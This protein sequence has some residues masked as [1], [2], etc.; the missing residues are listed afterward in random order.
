[1][2]CCMSYRPYPTK[3][4]H[5]LRYVLRNRSSSEVYLVILFTLYLKEDIN[6]DGSLKPAAVE[7]TKLAS[8]RVLRS[9][10]PA[11]HDCPPINE[12]GA[13]EEARR[14]FSAVDLME[15]NGCE[16]TNDDDVD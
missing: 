9:H 16:E 4:S 13:L 6:E 3:R 7:A 10:D 2:F 5:Q 8:D 14:K 1:M 15:G 12:Q 11:L